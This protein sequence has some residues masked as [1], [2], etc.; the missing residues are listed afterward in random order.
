VIGAELMP[1]IIKVGMIGYGGQATKIENYLS[2]KYKKTEVIFFNYKNKI[3]KSRYTNKLDDLLKCDIIF[4]CSP[5]KT[6]FKYLKKFL[7]KKYIFCEKPPV[8]NSKEINYLRNYDNGKVFYNYNMRFSKVYKF[9]NDC[10]LKKIG[11]F[12]DGEIVFSHLLGFQKKYKENWRSKKKYTQKGVYEVVSIHALDLIK[13]IFKNIR[14][15]K[16]F[17]SNIS[18]YG[19]SIDTALTLA[20]INKNSFIKIFCS[21]CA[22]YNYKIKLIYENAIIDIDDKN[23]KFFHPCNKI[24]NNGLS[25]RP[26]IS[27]KINYNRRTDYINSL[28]RSI[29]YFMNFYLKNKK[30]SHSEKK[31]ALDSNR[32]II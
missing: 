19:N 12:I 25:I 4:I 5:N 30:F 1:S 2:K 20:Q 13:N 16:N 32:F 31:N 17:F 22:P 21:Y 15:V 23:L 11:K 24:G 28:H 14:I 7:N 10:S 26:K 8:S 29:D 9:I 3:L 18:K 27:K 6:H